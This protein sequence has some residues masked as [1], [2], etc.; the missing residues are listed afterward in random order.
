MSADV[1]PGLISDPPFDGRPSDESLCWDPEPEE[2]VVCSSPE[3]DHSTFDSSMIPGMDLIQTMCGVSG[4]RM[5]RWHTLGGY[6]WR[7]YLVCK[8]SYLTVNS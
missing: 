5:N 6:E 7:R 1:S 3:D 8:S 2:P 4:L